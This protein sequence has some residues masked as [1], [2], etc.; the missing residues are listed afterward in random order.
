LSPSSPED[1]TVLARGTINA[2]GDELRVE[3]RRPADRPAAERTL[4]H[5]RAVVV[6]VWPAA[7]TV[8][9]PDRYSD[10]AAFLTRLFAESSISLAAIKASRQ[11]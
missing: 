8:V 10:V 6:V 11:L 7:P 5:R 3:L 9:S 2:S 1:V 4:P